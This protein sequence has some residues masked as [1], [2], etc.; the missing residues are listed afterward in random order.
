MTHP[1]PRCAHCG[2]PLPKGTRA[3]ALYCK[4]GHR[5]SAWRKRNHYGKKPANVAGL[6]MF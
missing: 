5:V 4:P 2:K 6:R 1:R 3:D